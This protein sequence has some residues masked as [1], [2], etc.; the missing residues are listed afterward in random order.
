MRTQATRLAIGLITAAGL[1]LAAAP[2]AAQAGYQYG[3][4]SN[5]GHSSHGQSYSQPHNVIQHGPHAGHAHSPYEVPLMG[6]L[7]INGR[8]IGIEACVSPKGQLINAFRAAGYT[9]NIGPCGNVIIEWPR[10]ARPSIRWNE[11]GWDLHVTRQ[12]NCLVLEL[13]EIVPEPA[14]R[15]IARPVVQPV[16]PVRP[17]RPVRPVAQPTCPVQYGLNQ[18]GSSQYGTATYGLGRVQQESGWSVSFSFGGNTA[19]RTGGR[20]ARR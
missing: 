17:S 15:P 7:V 4:G 10:K 16:R 5:R 6:T 13:C 19:E 14:V 20:Y 18:Y 11:C 1:G 8:Q 9:A 3:Y 12:G 2:A